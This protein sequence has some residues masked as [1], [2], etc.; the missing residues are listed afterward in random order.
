M[1][2]G[3]AEFIA[4][5][6]MDR[7]RGF[8]WSPDGSALL[9]ARVD[10]SPVQRWWIADPARPDQAPTEVAYPAAGTPNAD[11]SAW[12]LGVD[13]ARTEVAWDRAAWP[14]LAQAG[15]D[16]HGP[17]VALMPAR[18]ALDRG[19][20]GRPGRRHHDVAVVRPGSGM[21]GAPA[22]DAGAPGRR[23]PRRGCRPRRH[24]PAR[25]RRG[26]RHAGRSARAR[27]QRRR[28]VA[29]GVHRQPDRRRDRARCSGAGRAPAS[30]GSRTA[31]AC[32]RAP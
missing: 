6:E 29:R 30:S 23:P 2:W 18:P 32:T 31:P 5:E 25:H 26:G 7:Y 4:A 12:L 22:R 28:P 8:W 11:V 9:V 16:E 3:V 13:G 21:G 14:Y 19:A 1:R 10:D 17:L 20:I 27:R 15:W 24:S